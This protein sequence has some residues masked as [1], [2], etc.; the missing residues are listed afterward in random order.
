MQAKGLVKW[1]AIALIL[2]CLY[3]LSFTFLA[4]RVESKATNYATEAVGG[5]INTDEQRAKFKIAK[6]QFLDSVANKNIVPGVTYNSAKEKQ[7]GLGLDLQG[8]MN[9]VLQ[10]SLEE[11]I[12]KMANN[13]S[14]PNFTKAIA[15]ARELQKSSDLD[16]VTLFGRAFNEVAPDGKLSTYF[17][18]AEYQSKINS[19]SSND[20]VLKV[21]KDEAS[22]AV[23]RTFEILRTRIDKFGVASP[24]INLQASTG[25]ILVELPGV[26]DAERVRNLL[27]ST[28]KLE[29]WETYDN[30]PELS[31]SFQG[32]NDALKKAL[33]GNA[34]ATPSAEAAKDT[35][36]AATQAPAE[37]DAKAAQ[38]DTTKKEI[39]LLNNDATASKDTSKA[40]LD[41]FKKDNPFFA[42]FSQAPQAGPVVGYV[43][44]ADTGTFRR[45]MAMPQVKAAFPPN[46]R[47]LFGKDAFTSE[48]KENGSTA[49]L[50]P[51]YAM[52]S[53][54][55][56][57]TAPLEGDVI[58]DARQD[59]DMNQK[60][61]VNM[62]M[63]AEG[64][65]IWKQLTSDNLGKSIAIVLDDLVYSAPTVQS[66]ISGGNSQITGNFTINEATDLANILKAGKLPAPA[67]VVQY[68]EVGPTLGAKSI[69]AGLMS[70]GFAILL[71]LAFLVLYY[72]KAGLVADLAVVLN[73][74][75]ILGI[76]SSLGATLTLAGMAGIILTMGIGVDASVIA[77]ER[78]RE[79][80]R[81]GESLKNAV[82]HGYQKSYSAIIDGNVT[83]LL[84]ACILYYYGLGPVLGFATV[85]IIG[86]FSSLFTSLL[87]ARLLIERWVNSGKDLQFSTP[88]SEGR[89]QNTH[90]DF[91]K[92]RRIGYII[93]ISIMVIGVLSMVFRGF[94]YGVDFNGGRTYIVKFPQAVNVS[95]VRES[96]TGPFNAAPVVQTFG[97][98]DQA[99]ITTS[100]LI[101]ETT[102]DADNQALNKLYEGLKSISG[103]SSIEEFKA[104]NLQSSQKV[105]PS[106]ADDIKRGAVWAGLLSLLGIFAYILLRFRKW[107]FAAGAVF[108]TLHDGMFMLAFFSLLH[109]LLPFSLEIDQHFIAA[110]LTILGYS[111]N[112]TVVIF[113][114]IREFLRE[115]PHQDERI[116]ANEAINSTLSRTLVT[117]LV[118]LSVVMLLFLFGGEVIRGF[119]FALAIGVLIGTYSSI[120]IAAPLAIDLG[121]RFN[122][123]LAEDPAPSKAEISATP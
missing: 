17:A 57:F 38:A 21:I 65:R 122:T 101:T 40:D 27:Q 15:R 78:I 96:L 104:K 107:P 39:D 121:R 9:V 28:A 83:T 120:F 111:I 48:N 98:S 61:T 25:R 24:N 114:R 49:V 72:N 81:S 66:E 112:D 118:T 35:A 90:Y 73:L 26:S 85:L 6:Q 63:N 62:Q 13:P 1:F 70:L 88:L 105:G 95:E 106:I 37:A 71:L 46:S 51:V 100:Y 108:A 97:G 29:F 89:F 47:L 34:A 116:V 2:V 110:F 69:Q 75:F 42:V 86:I 36:K 18:T 77:F 80:L 10:V 58:T 44:K 74:F 3:Q 59:F 117:S 55:S 14:D 22:S 113:D 23:E 115:N 99:K 91:Y 119:A 8:G 11:L 5:S 20:D 12:L 84:T 102:A 79:E 43:A 31:K 68:E 16:F 54:S 19:Q 45:Y 64:A 52:R 76:L 123:P 82:K 41:K 7:L 56:D 53:R 67:R 50:F 32:A 33:S 93:S 94:E 92:I 103:T 87:I 60:V 4:R 109:G 30:S